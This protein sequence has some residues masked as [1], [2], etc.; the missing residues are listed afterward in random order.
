MFTVD[1]GRRAARLGGVRVQT[2]IQIGLEI[3]E[4]GHLES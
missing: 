4:G 1:I 2:M 3:T